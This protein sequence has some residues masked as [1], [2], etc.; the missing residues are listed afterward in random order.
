MVR[1]RRNPR[2]LKLSDRLRSARKSSGLS[3]CALGEATGVSD[4]VVAYLEDGTR[5]PRISTVVQLAAGLGVSPG[6]LAYGLGGGSPAVGQDDGLGVSGRLAKRR[7][8]LGLSRAVLAAAAGVTVTAVQ[9]IED[10]RRVPSVE[11]VERLAVALDVSPAW[12]AFGEG[13]RPDQNYQDA[14]GA[15]GDAVD[16]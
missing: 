1:G 15:D 16:A 7:Q 13:N 5:T 4:T 10:A 6:W 2:Y 9:H 8:H 14:I 12:L 11:T 3:R